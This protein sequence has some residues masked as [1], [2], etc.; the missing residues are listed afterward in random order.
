MYLTKAE[1]IENVYRAFSAN[2]LD[3]DDL[4]FFSETHSARGGKPFRR[5]I[6]QRLNTINDV[7]YKYLMVGYRGCGKSTELA[8]LQEEIEHEINVGSRHL[9]LSYSI[10]NELD[11][12]NLNYIQLF[13]ITMEKLFET[14]EKN[15]LPIN[16]EYLTLITHRVKTKEIQEINDTYNLYEGKSEIKF[17]IP[18]FKNF[19]ANFR[20]SST[21]S[22]SMKEVIKQVIEPRLSELINLCNGLITEV[23]LGLHKIDKDNLLIII[24]DFDKIT[25]DKAKEIFIDHVS[26]ITQLN[27][28]MIFTFPISLYYSAWWSSQIKNYFHDFYEFPMIKVHEKD[29]S[30]STEGMSCMQDM[31]EK[32]MNLSLFESKEILNAMIRM[33]GGALWDLFRLIR[34]AADFAIDEN[35]KQISQKDY[36]KALEYLIND[37]Q[38]TITDV[39]IEGK[40]YLSDRFYEILIK[41]SET[42]TFENSIEM[43]H[44]RQTLLVLGYNGDF[45]CDIHPVVKEILKRKNKI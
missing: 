44:L 14:I 12:V 16:H 4:A 40:L 20:L 23:K 38:N 32:R 3:K 7:D 6:L 5:R 39:T 41:L 15:K 21:R 27:V 24:E 28:N 25:Y 18:F 29:G 34:D 10:K 45:W 17:D 33:C 19:F 37:Y 1:S 30:D 31:I 26:T 35:R 22:T 36:L 43:L 42:K 8:K 2:P 11:P 13:I 9:V